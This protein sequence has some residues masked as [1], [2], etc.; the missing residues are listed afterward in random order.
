[1]DNKL[2]TQ[3]DVNKI[4]TARVNREREKLTKEFEVK[5][6]QR[7]TSI[8]RTLLEL[9]VNQDNLAVEMQ[10]TSLTE[11]GGDAENAEYIG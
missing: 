1:M 3:S 4:V 10:E 9:F 2:F 5:L 7:M 8:Q 11:K 6:R